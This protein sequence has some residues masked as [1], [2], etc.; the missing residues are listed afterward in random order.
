MCI[1]RERS[2][3]LGIKGDCRGSECLESGTDSLGSAADTRVARIYGPHLKE[4][5]DE[6]TGYVPV[7]VHARRGI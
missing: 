1:D 4:K 6:A 5:V 7:H 3:V 2:L